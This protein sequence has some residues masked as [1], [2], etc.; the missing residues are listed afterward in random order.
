[1]KPSRITYIPIAIGATV[2]I[3]LYVAIGWWGFLLL[4]PWIGIAVAIGIYLQQILKTKK[5]I[6]GRKV[7]II[8]ILPA[9]LLFVP[10]VNNENFQ[11]EGVFLIVLVGYFSKGFIH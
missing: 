2:G 5:K 3:S 4:F 7:S 8:L 11:L 1:M 10:L 9:L 6:L